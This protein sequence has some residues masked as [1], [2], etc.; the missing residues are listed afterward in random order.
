MYVLEVKILED[1]EAGPVFLVVEHL[2]HILLSL[3]VDANQDQRV[4]EVAEVRKAR[5][6]EE[7]VRIG[8]VAGAGL[9]RGSS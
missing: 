6:V 8:W 4:E 5:R 7:V 1:Q 9:P 3:V 2:V